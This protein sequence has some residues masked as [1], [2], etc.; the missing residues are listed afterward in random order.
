M[1]QT[2]SIAIVGAMVAVTSTLTPVIVLTIQNRTRR[3][4]RALE[5]QR[6]DAIAA[7]VDEAARI[8][9]EDA[10][11]RALAELARQEANKRL[12]EKVDGVHTLVNDNL[13]KVSTALAVSIE[14]NDGLVQ[15]VADLEKRLALAQ[16][17]ADSIKREDAAKG[18][19]A[20]LAQVRD[21]A[22]GAAEGLEKVR[23]ATPGPDDDLLGPERTGK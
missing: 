8:L 20:G 6:A 10:G 9:A 1:E 18:A 5:N 7:K 12:V 3:A 23:A 19:A 4:E 15:R 21:A 13:T 2:L 16:R 22:T 14:K 17:G 11:K